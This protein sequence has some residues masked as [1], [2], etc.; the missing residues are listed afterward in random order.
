MN[1]PRCGER[2]EQATVDIGVGEIPCGPLGCE[3]CHWVE[4]VPDEEQLPDARNEGEVPRSME[5]KP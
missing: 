2:L 4:G 1:C 5:P 3:C